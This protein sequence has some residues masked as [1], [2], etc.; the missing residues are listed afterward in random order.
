MGITAKELLYKQPSEN[1]KFTMD[2]TN[3]L[4]SSTL[5]SLV[6]ISHEYINGEASDLGIT[7]SGLDTTFKKVDMFISNGTA[8]NKYRIEILVT[9]NDGQTL[10]GDGILYVRDT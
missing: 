7:G 8:N 6:S 3:K 5:A 2:F 9:T 4:G 1:A 10:E